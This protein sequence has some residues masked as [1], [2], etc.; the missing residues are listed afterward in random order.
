ML[1]TEIFLE[2]Y[3]KHIGLH[4]F[5]LP[6][7]EALTNA[8]ILVIGAGALG[9]PVLTYLAAMGL[10][11]LGIV[12]QGLVSLASLPLQPLYKANQ[13]AET[14]LQCVSQHLRDLNPEVKL[15]LYDFPLEAGNA[16]EI[17][18]QY[19]VVIDATNDLA[20]G[21]LVNDAC[22]LA[23]VPLVLGLVHQYEGQVGVLNFKGGATLRCMLSDS[24]LWAN[25]KAGRNQGVL[26]ILPGIIGCYMASEA[27]KIIGGI[28]EVLTNKVLIIDVLKNTQKEIKLTPDPENLKIKVLQ[29]QYAPIAEAEDNKKIPSI[30]PH[31]LALKLSYQEAVQLIDIRDKTTT[32]V[33]AI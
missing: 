30:T 5:G 22:V 14:M 12:E 23:G 8:S 7:Q 31:Q 19:D 28:G 16:L 4:G 17:I 21:Y 9:V 32:G 27:V 15:Q 3:E 24:S 26:G 13:V 29:Q 33:S 6:G 1:N 2:R 25:L 11:R 18:P 20:S 10:G